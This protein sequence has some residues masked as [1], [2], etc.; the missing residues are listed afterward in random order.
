M[1]ATRKTARRSPRGSTRSGKAATGTRTSHAALVK[2]SGAKPGRASAAKPAS[3]KAAKPAATK[4]GATKPAAAKPARDGAAAVALHHEV[5]QFLY[6]QSESL[7]AKRW[8][9]YID[10][11]TSDGVY[12]M[13]PGPEY[14][15]WDG[16]PAIFIED[17][18]LMTVRMKRVM[19]PSAWSQQAEWATNHVVSN[20]VVEEVTADG[21]EVHVRSRFHLV[22]LRRDE[23]RHFAG[24]YRHHLLREDGG[25]RIK[26]QRVDMVNAQ[27]PYEYVL[28]I[29]V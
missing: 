4:R 6:R 19:H 10:L 15:T 28:Q 23:L 11:F 24:T 20:V 17:R 12:W 26:L 1:T 29:W 25:F 14:T 7:D 9:D 2:T 18:N 16:V 3:A 13:P 27:A 22:E 5:A 8:Q 21:A